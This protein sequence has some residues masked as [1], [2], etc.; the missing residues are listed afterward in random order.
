MPS[1]PLTYVLDAA[2]AG[3]GAAGPG[4]FQVAACG[5]PST[6]RGVRGGLNHHGPH[7]RP[8]APPQLPPE[9][10]AAACGELSV[11]LDWPQL[12]LEDPHAS[13]V[14]P[15]LT[16]HQALSVCPSPCAMPCLSVYLSLALCQ[17]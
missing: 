8:A 5:L 11:C 13:S 6:D 14:C 17:S 10:P 9:R 3:V 15:S 16:P 7:P 1:S 4:Q 2:G 12:S